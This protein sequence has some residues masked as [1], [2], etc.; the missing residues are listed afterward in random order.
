MVATAV[1][2][3]GFLGHVQGVG[4]RPA[5]GRPVMRDSTADFEVGCCSWPASNWPH[6]AAGR[7]RSAG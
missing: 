6:W 5:S 7:R 3:D 2:P 1:H 4:D